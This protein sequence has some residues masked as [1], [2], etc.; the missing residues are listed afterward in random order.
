MFFSSLHKTR[1]RTAGS[2]LP[3]NHL[4]LA[5]GPYAVQLL[6]YGAPDL[7]RG[8]Q[9]SVAAVAGWRHRRFL[10]ELRYTL[11]LQSIF[12]DRDGVAA[13]LVKARGF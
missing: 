5:A 1:P 8:T 9:T 7:L 12:K 13:G 2:L 3:L 6:A 4:Y 10:V 11:G